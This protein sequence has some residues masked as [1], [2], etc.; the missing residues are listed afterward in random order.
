MSIASPANV[1]DTAS[2]VPVL[3]L[4][5]ITKSFPGVKALKGVSFDVRAG[6]VHCAARRERRR[7]VDP[8]QDHV[9]RAPA[10][11]GTMYLDGKPFR[12]SSPHEARQR[13]RRHHLPGAAALSRADRRREHL[14]G[15]RA[16][17]RAGAAWTGRRC[18]A[19]RRSSSP[20][21]TSTTSIRDAVVGT[22]SVGNRQ[23][24]EILRALSQ[25]ARILIM[26]EPTAALTERDVHA[27]LRHRAA[28][29]RPGR[30][31][32]STSATAW[33]RSSSSADRVTV[34]RDGEHVAHP[35][36]GRD[37]AGRA[38]PDD[39]RPPD[40]PA[41]PQGR[42]S[43]SASR[44]WRRGTC[45]ASRRRWTS[46]SPSAPARSSGSP[47]S[48]APA[49]ASS[50]RPSSASRPPPPARSGSN[51]KAGH[52]SPRPR[53]PAPSASPMCRRTAPRRGSCGR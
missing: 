16:D 11:T 13:G 23:R 25:D 41:L 44:C 37:E 24:V 49:A 14:H 10:D 42:R 39:G 33:T 51:G 8:D 48:S 5:G 38:H 17:A 15:P 53:T 31:A 12:L 3:R 32:S 9:R 47:A 21:S 29:A 1:P 46:A 7:Q 34:L 45:G 28:A 35:H 19:R 43:R 2:A 22:L 36:R 26:D 18:G 27:A 4:E 40:R 52:A 6:E 20:R 50:R 30:R